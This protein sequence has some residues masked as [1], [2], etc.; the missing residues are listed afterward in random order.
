MDYLF[1]NHLCEV[2]QK[3]KFGFSRLDGVISGGQLLHPEFNF[4]KKLKKNY[5]S[6]RM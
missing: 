5:T 3:L 1:K 6:L 4:I 2:N